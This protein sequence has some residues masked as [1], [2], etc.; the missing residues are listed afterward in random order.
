MKDPA[1]LSCGRSLQCDLAGAA[2][3]ASWRCVHAQ[4]PSSAWAHR[5]RG[6][7]RDARLARGLG[8]P[9]NLAARSRAARD[10]PRVRTG[11]MGW[12]CG[13]C[14]AAQPHRRRPGRFRSINASIR[15][16]PR[17]RGRPR[18]C[19]QDYLRRA[20][21]RALARLGGRLDL[22]PTRTSILQDRGASTTTG[23]ARP[24]VLSSCVAGH[25][26]LPCAKAHTGSVS[27]STRRVGRYLVGI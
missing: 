4:E 2:R 5:A 13:G 27:Q 22:A 18:Q 8:H 11:D 10:R 23:I 14:R 19:A 21:A 6:V 9:G 7:L 3:P 12:R 16:T 24:G 25:P 1:A 15:R 17:A 26:A 20:Q